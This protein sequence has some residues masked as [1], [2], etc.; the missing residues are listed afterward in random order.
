MR[1]QFHSSLIWPSHHF[2]SQTVADKLMNHLS[3][4][5]R[6][7]FFES[8]RTHHAICSKC[9]VRYVPH[10]TEEIQTPRFALPKVNGDLLQIDTS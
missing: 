7:V 3:T 8:V 1:H 5:K 6:D 10:M 9:I 4:E 2:I